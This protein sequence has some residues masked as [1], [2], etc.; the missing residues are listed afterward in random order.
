[1]NYGKFDNRSWPIRKIRFTSF[2]KMQICIKTLTGNKFIL[3]VEPT[4]RIEDVKAQL[5]DKTGISPDQVR[6]IFAGKELENGHTLQDCSI[7]NDSL[8]NLVPPRVPRMK[9]TIMRATGPP[10][11]LEVEASDL[12]EDL[13]SQIQDKTGSRPG[14]QTL[15]WHGQ[16]LNDGN[17]LEY[18]SIRNGSKLQLLVPGHDGL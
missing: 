2:A 13:K 9:I 4:D 7:P 14:Q 11:T 6:L 12:I 15:L 16:R 18:Y 10:I 1:M 8:L 3:D 5:R 17:R